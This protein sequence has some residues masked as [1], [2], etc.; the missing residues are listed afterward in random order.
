MS[1]TIN[2]FQVGDKVKLATRT[3]WGIGTLKYDK[4]I[5]DWYIELDIPRKECHSASGQGKEKS[6]WFST[7]FILVSKG[8]VLTKEE[9][10]NLKCKT[11]WNKSK[12]VEKNPNLAY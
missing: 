7:G 12:Y 11:L 8:K 5:Y 9:R 10:I 3:S 4:K 1:Y 6:C 2:D